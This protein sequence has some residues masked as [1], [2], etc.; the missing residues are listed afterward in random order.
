MLDRGPR[1]LEEP[2]GPPDELAVRVHLALGAQ[3]AHE[4]PVEPRTV[5][6][7]EVLER[8]AE[9]DVNR[10]ADLLVEERVVR[11]PVDLV[12]EPERDLAEPARAVV[13]A[14]HGV[15]VLTAPVGLGGHDPAALEAQPDPV[16]LAAV[17]ERG[18]A[19]ADLALGDRFER[20][21]V[22]L[23]VGHVVAAVRGLPG[24]ALDADLQVGARAD[25]AQLARL[26]ERGRAGRKVVVHPPPVRDRVTRLLDVARA[27]DEALVLGERHLGVL[28]VGLRRELGAA[29]AELAARHPLPAALREL[30]R[31]GDQPLVP[32]G[33]DPAQRPRVRV[34][35]DGDDRVDLLELRLRDR[36]D[37]VQLLV[38]A[39]LEQQLGDA[40]RLDVDVRVR[41]RS[42]RGP[43][44]LDCEC[45]R[46]GR[47]VDAQH[48][49]GLEAERVV[50][51][52]VGEPPESLVSHQR[53]RKARLTKTFA[54]FGFIDAVI[55]I[56]KTYLPG[57]SLRAR[58]ATTRR[59]ALIT[60]WT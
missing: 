55:L 32:L 5:L 42:K 29:P 9:R 60:P 56:A 13:Q 16:D 44:Q 18:E 59:C 1:L 58:K 43:V 41:A 37:E 23:A 2:A 15:E 28:S 10:A 6:P 19:E 24:P 52:Q 7:A 26:G 54:R 33:V 48:L 50:D 25:D 35:P 51:D 20:A 11:E 21:G 14:Q 8:R 57:F 36:R 40:L 45:S 17:E 4:I 27:E 53:T 22:D 39:L 34:A 46:D 47:R 49:S 38:A 12:V 30:L 31:R 3:V